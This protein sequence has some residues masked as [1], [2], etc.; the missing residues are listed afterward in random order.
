MWFN[1]FQFEL[2][3]RKGRPATYLYFLILFF[4]SFLA[5]TTDVVQIGGSAGKIKENA[6][7]VVTQMQI[8][9]CSLVGMLMASAIMGVAV[10]RD[11]EYR[12]EALFFTAPIRKIDYLLGRYLGSMVVL[13]FVLLGG[14]LG[15]MLGD[16]MPWRE[17]DK[18]LP[19]SAA[20]FFQPFFVF[21]VTNA[22]ISGSIFFA[23]GALSRRMVVVFSQGMVLLMAYLIGNSLLSDLENKELAALIDPFGIRTFPS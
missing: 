2:S 13:L 8:I 20:T 15:F 1:I 5:V 21:V 9:L 11:F 16:F 12:T 18:L 23:V 3:Y 10:V 17:A 22:F 7:F 19:F 4:L 14:T 6:P